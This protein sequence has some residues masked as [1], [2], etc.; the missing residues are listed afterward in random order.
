MSLGTFR[1]VWAN[2]GLAFWGGA[3]PTAA[4][5]SWWLLRRPGD[6]ARQQG[7]EE[8]AA[9]Y[10]ESSASSCTGYEQSVGATGH[11]LTVIEF[12]CW[13][14]THATRTNEGHYPTCF[15]FVRE[16]PAVQICIWS[17]TRLATAQL[18]STCSLVARSQD[19]IS[20][21]LMYDLA[22]TNRKF[23]PSNSADFH[24]LRLQIRVGYFKAIWSHFHFRKAP[25]RQV[26]PAV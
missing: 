1:S 2:V 7:G 12:S 16:D 6:A 21:I 26:A 17:S 18:V 22:R 3:G 9:S 4:N 10:S 13:L 8:P 15:V 5:V 19:R 23:H 14:A 24:A 25:Y 11:R 20:K